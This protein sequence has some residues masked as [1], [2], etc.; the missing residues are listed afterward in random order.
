M[1][2]EKMAMLEKRALFFEEPPADRSRQDEKRT[3]Y[4]LGASADLKRHT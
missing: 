4:N 1:S 2:D 3:T